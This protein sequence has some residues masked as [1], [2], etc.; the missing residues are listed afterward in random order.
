MLLAWEFAH[1]EEKADLRLEFRLCVSELGGGNFAGRL[2]RSTD[3]RGD[4]A[5]VVQQPTLIRRLEADIG[6]T[7]QVQYRPETVVAVR[8]VVAVLGCTGGKVQSAEDDIKT[9]GQDIRFELAHPR[10][11]V[12]SGS[13]ALEPERLSTGI[14]FRTRNSVDRRIAVH[15]SKVDP[16]LSRARLAHPRVGRA[17][18]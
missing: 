17:G 12:L 5:A 16:C 15:L 14:Y 7:R 1:H 6:E 4:P 9:L 2:R 8:E 18:G 10:P 13:E 3:G 11:L